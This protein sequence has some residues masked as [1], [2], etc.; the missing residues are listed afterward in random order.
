MRQWTS[1]DYSGPMLKTHRLCTVDRQYDFDICDVPAA[2]VDTS[3][4]AMVMSG[5]LTRACT[6]GTIT[7][8]TAGQ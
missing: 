6:F 4:G 7:A 8:R 2:P 1:P 5:P 3:I